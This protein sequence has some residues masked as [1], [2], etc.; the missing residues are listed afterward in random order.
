MSYYLVLT[1]QNHSLKCIFIF[2][3]VPTPGKKIYTNQH[4]S[5]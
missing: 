4:F 3:A 2:H 5:G 1:T